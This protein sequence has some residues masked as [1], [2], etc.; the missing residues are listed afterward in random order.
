M[1]ALTIS[2]I[3]A[4]S[5]NYIW[6]IHDG[7]NAYVVDP[8]EPAPVMARLSHEGLVLSGVLITH[9]HFDHTGGL[10]ELQSATG[11]KSWG[12]ANSP[13]GPYD[14][15]LRE[16]DV[17][18]VLGAGFSVLEVPGH[19]LDHIAFYSAAQEALFCGDTLFVGGCGRVF[20]GNPPQMRNSLEKLRRLPPQT[21]IFCAHEYTLANLRFARLVEP[22][23]RRLENFLDECEEKR[24]Q[25]MATVPSLLGEEREYNPFLRWDSPAILATLKQVSRSQ[26]DSFDEVFTAVREWKNQA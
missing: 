7:D 23:N 26:G 10:A 20:E 13:G 21:Q 22:N 17:V 14:H 9:H 19:T 16:G 24:R 11:C 1:G 4:F 2:P 25:N 3:N 18:N 15:T 8:G 6:L 12:P 5:G